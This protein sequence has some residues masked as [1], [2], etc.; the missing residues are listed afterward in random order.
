VTTSE[1]S[2]LP[3]RLPAKAVKAVSDEFLP[4]YRQSGAEPLR[5]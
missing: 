2:E 4:I 3:P 5:D 1:N